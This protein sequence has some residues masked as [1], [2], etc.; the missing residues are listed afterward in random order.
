MQVQTTFVPSSVCGRVGRHSNV[1]CQVPGFAQV[2][3]HRSLIVDLNSYFD[4]D[5]LRI[6]SG[7]V[8]Q[9]PRWQLH[10]FEVGR[11]FGGVGPASDRQRTSVKTGAAH[12]EP[13]SSGSLDDPCVRMQIGDVR[14][15]LFVGPPRSAGIPRSGVSTLVCAD[16]T[17]FELVWSC[18]RRSRTS[19]PLLAPVR[20]KSGAI[21]MELCG[22]TAQSRTRRAF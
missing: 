11:A 1:C 9:R 7:V 17:N 6:G 8:L 21:R 22:E 2:I 13:P 16:R 5:L 3:G 12:E 10:T 15:Y 19:I 14:P 20:L 18:E 4:V